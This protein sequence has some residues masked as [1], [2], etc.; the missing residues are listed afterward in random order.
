MQNFKKD[1]VI[2]Y[3]VGLFLEF[4]CVSCIIEI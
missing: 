4:C 3:I 1:V 2:I